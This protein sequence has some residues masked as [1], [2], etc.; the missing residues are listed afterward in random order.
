[1]SLMLKCS[2]LLAL[3]A[4]SSIMGLFDTKGLD[5]YSIPTT[6]V[7]SVNDDPTTIYAERPWKLLRRHIRITHHR[8]D[9]HEL[10]EAEYFS[11]ST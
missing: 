3:W 4:N 9:L 8:S 5:R 2:F 11:T 1:M 10:G 7:S 6:D